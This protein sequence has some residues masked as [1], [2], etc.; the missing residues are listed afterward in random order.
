MTKHLVQWPLLIFAYLALLGFGLGDNYRSPLYPRILEKYQLP[1]AMGSLFFALS[2]LIALITNMLNPWWLPRLKPIGGLKVFL[3]V[4]VIG[5]LGLSWTLSQNRPYFEV[6][7]FSMIFGC[8]TGG[9]GICMNLLV[10]GATDLQFRRQAF[11]GLHSMYGL[12]SIVAPV[13]YSFLLKNNLSP[14]LGFTLIA[15]LPLIT[16]IFL[17]GQKKSISS[18]EVVHAKFSMK[19]H[20]LFGT[21]VATYVASEILLSTRL[22]LYLERVWK[23]SPL[24]ANFFLMLFFIYLFSGRLLLSLYQWKFPAHKL[25]AG[26]LLLG[27]LFYALGLYYDPHFLAL[28]GL[29]MSIFFPTVM[30]Y[31]SVIFGKKSD[32]LIASILTSMGFCIIIVHFGFGQ[33]VTYFGLAVSMHLGII[34]LFISLIVLIIVHKKQESYRNNIS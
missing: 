7:F 25:L 6:L 22:P 2:S 15:A 14:F 4:Q 12:S 26:S 19:T 34:F 20:W 30:E 18:P 24:E 8:S 28:T 16:A 13:F 9:L 33:L 17:F 31:V 3:L 29:S 23:L 27:M 11:A 10:N 5:Y 32:S 21:L 1:Y